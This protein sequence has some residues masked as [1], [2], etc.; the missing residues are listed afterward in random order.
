MP[1]VMAIRHSRRCCWKKWSN[2]KTTSLPLN[3][4][5]EKSKCAAGFFAFWTRYMFCE[6]IMPKIS[7]IVP[8]YQVEHY[9]ARCVN[10]VKKQTFRDFECILVDD[11]ST[12]GSGMLCDEYSQNELNFYVVHKENGGLSSARNAALEMAQGEYLCFLDSDDLL[13]PQALEWMLEAMEKTGADLV[14]TGLR[15]FT[16]DTVSMEPVGHP[17]I[18]TVGQDVFID[19]LLPEN[20]GR[21]SVTACGKLYRRDIF[22]DLRFPEGEIYEDLH[23][24]LKVLLSCEKIAILD[25][26]L[27]WYYRNPSSITRSEYLAY[28]RFGEFEVRE[29]Y[30]R[31]FKERGLQEQV[32]YAENDYLTFF[33]RN[34][35]AVM[36]CYPQ[37]KEA[38]KAHVKVFKTHLKG[39]LSNPYVCRMRKICALGMLIWPRAVYP[40]ARRCIPDCL[41]EEM[42]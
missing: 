30:I 3:R 19:R 10:S 27:Y 18:E 36:L 37:R 41:I 35:L 31:F 21:V 2:S 42:R 33:M 20:F 7:I 32:H 40:V 5:A 6:G 22:R 28:D 12:D 8:V 11:G 26:P 16:T 15:E 25:A 9:L 17:R 4:L 24:Y 29:S 23:V 1:G 39:I 38:M 13:H 14:T 34:Y